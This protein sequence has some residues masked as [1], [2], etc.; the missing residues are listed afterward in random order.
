MYI[1]SSGSSCA[2]GPNPMDTSNERCACIISRSQA[3]ANANNAWQDFCSLKFPYTY[4]NHM[5]YCINDYY[6][7]PSLQIHPIVD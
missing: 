4:V 6:T 2:L 7:S 1:A 3:M 5:M